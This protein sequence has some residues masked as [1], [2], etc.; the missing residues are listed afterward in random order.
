[1]SAEVVHRLGA[2]MGIVVAL[3]SVVWWLDRVRRRMVREAAVLRGVGQAGDSGCL[4]TAGAGSPAAVAAGSGGGVR[5]VDGRRRS[6]RTRPGAGG[7]GGAVVVAS[8]TA[9]EGCDE[10]GRRAGR[11][12]AAST[13]GRSAGGVHRGGRGAG[14]RGAGRGRGAG[15]SR[16][17]SLGARCR[18]GAAGRRTLRCL[19]DVG[20]GTRCGRAGP[21]AGEGRRVRSP[22]GGA[23]CP[24]RGRCPRRLGPRRRQLGP[25]GR[26]SWCPHRWGCV[27]CLPSS[28]WAS[29]PS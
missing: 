12:P 9:D 1:M 4:A 20:L 15:R 26:Q 18:R 6:R 24:D 17:R 7:G 25:D 3:G 2:V 28:R 5:R 16:R 8:Q 13:R 19:A 27:S 11:G 14:D 22:G 23:G 10:R 29:C 21:L